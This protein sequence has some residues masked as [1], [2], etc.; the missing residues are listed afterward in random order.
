[1]REIRLKTR[2]EAQTIKFGQLLAEQLVVKDVVALFGDL[3]SGKTVLVKGI[4]KGLGIKEEITSPSFTIISEYT[5]RIPLFHFD[6]YR[7]ENVAEFFDLDYENYF[8]GNGVSVIEWA[9][10]IE[11]YLPDMRIDIKIKRVDRNRREIL[12]ITHK[13]KLALQMPSL[14]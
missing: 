3:G 1:M 5:G 12:L 14:D 10:K 11:P 13:R 7:I 6:L 4:G 2:S 8:F 9:D